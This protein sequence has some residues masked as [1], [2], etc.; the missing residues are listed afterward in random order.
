MEY[1]V[2][3]SLEVSKNADGDKKVRLATVEVTGPEDLRTVE[4]RNDEGNEFVPEVG[5]RLYFEEVSSDFLVSSSVGTESEPDESLGSGDRKLSAV[6]AGAP[7]A[8]IVLKPSGEI[9][10]N[11][12][13]DYAVKHNELVTLITS[14]VLQINALVTAFNAHVPPPIVPAVNVVLDTSKLIAN[15]VKL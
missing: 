6:K 8:N 4:I 11:E 9:S 14:L 13:T 15:K 3:K 1:G 10:L 7:K 2:I 5:S 12:G